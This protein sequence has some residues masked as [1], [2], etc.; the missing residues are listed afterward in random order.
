MIAPLK[1]PIPREHEPEYPE[2]DGKPMAETDEHRDLMVRVIQLLQAF[3]AHTVAYVSG[4]LLIYYEQGNPH[5]SVAPDCFVVKGVAQRRRRIYK[6]WEE[7]KAPDVVFEITSNKT[8]REDQRKKPQLYAQLG[9]KELFLFDPTADYL[10]PPLQGFRLSGGR[11]SALP[12]SDDGLLS[13]ELNLRIA[14]DAEGDL[15][16]YDRL[17]DRR[18]L[19]ADERAAQADERATAAE[20]EV[21]RL[22]AELARLRGEQA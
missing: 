16:F 5:R 11:Y 8:K 2:S 13:D 19:T 9:V 17:S 12:L 7:G 15:Q 1:P 3:L 20:A 10:R 21:A 4:N 22:R 14:L 18:L 6:L